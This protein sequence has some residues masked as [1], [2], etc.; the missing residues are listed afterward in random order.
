MIPMLL[1]KY[2]EVTITNLKCYSFKI[3]NKVIYVSSYLCIC[4]YWIDSWSP[5]SAWKQRKATFPLYVV[6]WLT[7][8]ESHCIRTEILLALFEIS[9]WRNGQVFY[10]LKRKNYWIDPHL[11]SFYFSIAYLPR[12]KKKC[13]HVTE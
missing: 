3:L 10:L 11:Y 9:F 13:W 4:G 5:F 1:M 8:M 7:L 12:C 6:L 2:V